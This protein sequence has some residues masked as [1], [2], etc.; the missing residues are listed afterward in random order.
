MTINPTQKIS[1]YFT[2]NEA[3]WLNEWDRLATEED[4][5]NQIIIDN[6]I[7]HAKKMDILRDWFNLPIKIRSWYR[8]KKYNIFIGG[9]EKSSHMLG[10]GTDWDNG[11]DCDI[12]RKNIVD[13]KL[14]EKLELRC[15]DKP[16][17]DWVHTDSSKVIK[18][19]YFKP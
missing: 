19:R 17:S 16:K 18:K 15:E 7:M 1:K 2:W 10:F 11:M 3:L 9:A 13:N 4:G 6:I 12:V 8:P 5:L 14:L